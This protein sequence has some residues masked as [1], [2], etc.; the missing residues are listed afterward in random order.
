MPLEVELTYDTIAVQYLDHCT[1]G[2]HLDIPLILV[3][4]NLK[5]N[6]EILSRI[7]RFITCIL[8]CFLILCGGTK[9]LNPNV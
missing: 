5:L 9:Q 8:L 7:K 1:T 6:L 3:N 4:K 2:A